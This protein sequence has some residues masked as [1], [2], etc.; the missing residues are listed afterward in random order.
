[1]NP[2]TDE[3]IE[4]LKC[5]KYTENTGKKIDW[6]CNAYNQWRETSIETSGVNCGKSIVEADLTKPNE[7]QKRSLRNSL[8]KFISQI[9]K[10]N[11]EDYP[12]KSL[13]E[14]IISIQMYLKT[15]RV[16][17]HLLNENDEIFVD[18]YNVT[19]NVM[20][21]CRKKGFGIIS[22]E[23]ENQMWEKGVLSEHNP[24]QLCT[25]VLYPIGVKFALR[26][27]SEHKNLR[28]PGFNQRFC[29]LGAKPQDIKIL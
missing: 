16:E 11:N 13:K 23:L 7:L 9:H 5:R 28:R 10:Y 26:G 14:L 3:E 24:K 12:P 17:W 4:E 15:K 27:G 19:D 29:T 20:K 18:L 2:L 8:Y 25:T 21:A 22:L 1:M 6:G